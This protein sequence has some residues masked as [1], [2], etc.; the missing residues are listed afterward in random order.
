MMDLHQ[1]LRKKYAL[2]IQN[3]GAMILMILKVLPRVDFPQFCHYI[4]HWNNPNRKHGIQ[5]DK[6]GRIGYN[7]PPQANAMM[8]APISSA[9]LMILFRDNSFPSFVA[10]GAIGDVSLLHGVG[11]DQG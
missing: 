3:L 1:R 9:A 7:I 10:L 2:I 11:R 5:V 8:T 6:N 4:L